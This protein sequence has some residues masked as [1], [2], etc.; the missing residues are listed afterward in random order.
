MG[1]RHTALVTLKELSIETRRLPREQAAVL[2]D[3]LLIDTFSEPDAAIHHRLG[4]RFFRHLNE[5]QAEITADPTLF[6]ILR[7]PYAPP[8][9][10][11]GDRFR[12]PWFTCSM[13]TTKKKRGFA[14]SSARVPLPARKS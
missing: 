8:G 1:D 7:P 14:N 3:L 9:G 10:T 6:R 12:M 2:M 5:L 13:A 11:F 4:P